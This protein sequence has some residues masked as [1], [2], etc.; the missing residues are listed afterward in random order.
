MEDFFKDAEVIGVKVPVPP[1]RIPEQPMSEEEIYFGAK[2]RAIRGFNECDYSIGLESGL[3]QI[4]LPGE[5][6]PRMNFA[7]CVI[8]DGKDVYYGHS[9]GF[10]VPRKIGVM[11]RR[12][13]EKQ[14][15]K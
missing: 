10:M 8:Y 3:K 15:E 4:P 12:D 5:N 2:F 6:L 14:A 9:S 13:S 7:A 1:S 11:L